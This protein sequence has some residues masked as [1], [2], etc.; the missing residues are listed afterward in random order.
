M[1]GVQVISTE[2]IKPSSPTPYHISSFK[3][4]MLDQQVSSQYIPLILFYSEDGDG[5]NKMNNV[6][7]TQ[8]LK[9]SLSETL[10]LFYPLAARIREPGFVDC[11]DEDV[12]FI[13]AR[14]NDGLS[15]FLKKVDME[16][17][18]NFVPCRLHRS[19]SGSDVLFAV[20]VNIFDCGGLAIG[21]DMLHQI[22]DGTFLTT[23]LNSWAATARG[24]NEKIIAKRFVFEAAKIEK[25]RARG[26]KDSTLVRPSKVEAVSALIWRCVIKI[27]KE[28]GFMGSYAAVH[29]VGLRKRM[30]PPLPENSIGNLWV[31]VFT[32]GILESECNEE[33][34][35]SCLEVQ[36]KNAIRKVDCDYVKELQGPAGIQKVY[37]SVKD[38]YEKH[39]KS[40]IEFCSFN[41]WC[42]FPIYEADFGWG[43]PTWV[44]LHPIPVKNM[45]LLVTTRSGDGIEVWV[46][47]E[48]DELAKFEQDQELLSF[49]AL[50]SIA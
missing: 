6:K 9:S 40:G 29:I 2:T 20:Q 5:Y 13:K 21:V 19:K 28:S 26:S 18:E 31:P 33:D 32:T 42:G 10:T 25:L 3:L 15:E 44:G 39:S 30:T 43:K 8:Q 1:W 7:K 38:L 11:N 12:Q 47:M 27:Q 37:E 17:L 50:P 14:V 35:K 22:G 34:M 16:L 41:S 45:F 48:E 23:L 49:V 4:S 36:L 46:N 24:S